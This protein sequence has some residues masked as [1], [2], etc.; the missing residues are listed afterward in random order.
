MVKKCFC[1]HTRT[2]THSDSLE[3]QQ[4]HERHDGEH[5]PEERL[6]ELHRPAERQLHHPRQTLRAD[7]RER[8]CDN[9]PES[10]NQTRGVF[11]QSRREVWK[12]GRCVGTL[13]L[14]LRVQRKKPP[15]SQGQ[16]AFARTLAHAHTGAHARTLT[17]QVGY[18]EQHE[19]VLDVPSVL[20]E[21]Q[22]Q[23]QQ[24]LDHLAT[25]RVAQ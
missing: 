24:N 3:L 2:H 22:D 16:N 23:Q 11:S 19:D 5:P 14:H 21:Q 15:R 4:A 20:H 7:H 12:S 10:R 18:E 1:T 17:E 25:E 13:P 8:R 9:Q 6:V